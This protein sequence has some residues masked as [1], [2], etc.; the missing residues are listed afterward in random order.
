MFLQIVQPKK[1]FKKSY[2]EN[3]CLNSAKLQWMIDPFGTLLYFDYNSFI[4]L[5]FMLRKNNVG[6]SLSQFSPRKKKINFKENL[7]F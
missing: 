1:A 5:F 7:F 6:Q 2:I 3:K 4:E